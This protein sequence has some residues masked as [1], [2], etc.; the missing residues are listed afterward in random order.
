MSMNQEIASN[1]SPPSPNPPRAGRKGRKTVKN[2]SELTP[3]ERQQIIELRQKR[4]GLRAIAKRVLRDR[5]KVRRVLTEQGL[6]TLPP[7]TASATDPTSAT[8]LDPFRATIQDKVRKDLTIS[9]ILREIRE[10]GYTGGRT[11]LAHY[12]RS[13]RAPL[14]PTKRAKR[15]FETRPGQESQVDWAVYLV[16]IAGQLTRIHAL[17]VILAYSRKVHVHFYRNE[18][19][20]TLLEGLAVAWETFRGV[21]MWVVFDN[22]ATVVLARVGPDRRPLWHPRFIEFARYYAFEARLCRVR[23]PDR[24]GKDEIFIRFLETDFIR[25]SEFAS[26]DDLNQRVHHWLDTV[27]NKRVHGTTGL[28]PDEAWLSERDFLIRLPDK[29]FATYQEVVHDVGPASTLSLYGTL[30]TVPDTLRNHSVLLRL[31]AHHFEVLNRDKA[32]VYSR[33]YVEPADKGKLQIDPSHYAPLGRQDPQVPGGRLDEAFLKRFPELAELVEGIQRRMKGLAPVHLRGLWRL[34]A[35]YGDKDFLSVAT[36]V[37]EHRR[38]D[39]GAVRRILERE[40]PLVESTPPITPAGASASVLAQ[41]SEVE[42]ASLDTYSHL[43]TTTGTLSPEPAAAPPSQAALPDTPAE[44]HA[45]A[46]HHTAIPKDPE[47]ET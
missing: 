46:S 6:L 19:E 30:Y 29:R 7:A 35:Q 28:V 42:P 16:P 36:R 20:S 13:L 26:F 24:K 4:Y 12:V 14:A 17:V 15:R 34:A 18:Q 10:L 2:T 5:K 3:E 8:K 44:P 43:D 45:C 25:G 47:H 11:I 27:A 41:V 32:V 40:H 23:D 39:A 31:Y 37:Q 21:T 1:P 9:R 38:F 33:A 22:M